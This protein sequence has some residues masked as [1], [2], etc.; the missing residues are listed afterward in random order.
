MAKIESSIKNQPYK[1][2]IKTPTGN[3]IV[4]DEPID[5]GG[6][7][8]GFSPKEL[9]ISALAACTSATVTMYAERKQWDLQEVKLE[10]ELEENT[11]EKKTILKRNIE[12]LGN[13]GEDQRTRL[14]RVAE[15]C[16]IHKIL[17]GSIE[18][19]TQLT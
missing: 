11:A 3:S 9:L 12:L 10:I 4:A 5:K 18:I 6:K 19:E 16:P 13:L 7:D 14:L 8:L 1:V 15:A 2:E 17:T